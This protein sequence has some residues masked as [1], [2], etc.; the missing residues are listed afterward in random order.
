MKWV[1]KN[2]KFIIEKNGVYFALTKEQIEDLEI[3]ISTIKS[4]E[5]YVKSKDINTK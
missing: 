2:N 3:L 5:E 4:S 1:F